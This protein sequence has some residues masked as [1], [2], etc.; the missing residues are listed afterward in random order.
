MPTEEKRKH[1]RRLG[2]FTMERDSPVVVFYDGTKANL[3]NNDLFRPTDYVWNTAG[4]PVVVIV[5]DDHE[6]LCWLDSLDDNRLCV[7][8]DNAPI[9][10]QRVIEGEFGLMKIESSLAQLRELNLVDRGLTLWRITTR[11]PHNVRFALAATAS[12]AAIIWKGVTGES[13]VVDAR[14]LKNLLII[15]TVKPTVEVTSE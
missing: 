9:A 3:L 7:I 15:P 13:G 2:I 10:H 8:E 5:H 12:A 6:G 4:C 14:P 11:K 1:H